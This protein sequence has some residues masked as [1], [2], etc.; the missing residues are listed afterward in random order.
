MSSHLRTLW[1]KWVLP[2]LWLVLIAAPSGSSAQE[3]SR[4]TRHVHA[5]TIEYPTNWRIDTSDGNFVQIEHPSGNA[6]C[7]IHSGR[8]KVTSVSVLVENMLKYEDENFKAQ[9]EPIARVVDRSKIEAPPKVT[10]IKILRDLTPGGRSLRY[11][12]INL[13]MLLIADCETG[14][15]NWASMESDFKSILD[16]ISFKETEA[17]GDYDAGVSAFRSGNLS[18]A[19]GLFLKSAE[20]GDAR[21]QYGIGVFLYEGRGIEKNTSIA[22][23]WL[24]KASQQGLLDAQVRFWQ[25]RLGSGFLSI[26]DAEEAFF[27]LRKAAEQGDIESQFQLAFQLQTGGPVLKKNMTEAM[28]WFDVLARQGIPEAQHE[29]GAILLD[30]VDGQANIIAAYGWL[31]L[32]VANGQKSSKEMQQE[33][34]ALLSAEDRSAMD[35]KVFRCL[36]TQ[37]RECRF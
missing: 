3:W 25:I 8:T 11:Y 22:M 6:L 29:L 37:Y 4:Y 1:E 28:H 33:A 20:G 35:A 2:T 16:S 34:A 19:V 24:L 13:G 32:A 21:G 17:A 12:F 31:S 36:E 10:G 30:G 18:K 9:G 27:W 7:G 15:T 23:T 14:Q 26:P 5:W